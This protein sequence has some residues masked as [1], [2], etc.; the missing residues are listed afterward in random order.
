[1][2]SFGWA[3]AAWALGIAAAAIGAWF[4]FRTPEPARTGLELI[5]RVCAGRAARLEALE[6]HVADPLELSAAPGGEPEGEH[7]LSHAEL[8][9]R[10]DERAALAPGCEFELE[11]WSIRPGPRGSAWLEGDLVYS[12]SQP[13]DLHARRRPLR[14]LFREV[15]AGARAG[16]D[17]ARGTSQPETSGEKVQRLERVVLGPFERHLPEAR[18]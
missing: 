10:L 4:F 2:K 13:S 1:M 5:A 17:G 16:E 6:R 8:E 7:T 14:A 11:D 18:P 9:A 12:D 3:D 15:S